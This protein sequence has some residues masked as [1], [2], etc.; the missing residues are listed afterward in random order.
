MTYAVPRQDVSSDPMLIAVEL[1]LET[2]GTERDECPLQ[3]L[4]RRLT[5]VWRASRLQS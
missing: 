3:G 1:P 5:H 4:L 2:W